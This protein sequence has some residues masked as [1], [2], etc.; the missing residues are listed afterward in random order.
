MHELVPDVALAGHPE[1]LLN[2]VRYF[3]AVMADVS[4]IL[5]EVVRFID[6]FFV[7]L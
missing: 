1:L 3:F 2:A 4:L 6:Q 5:A 7:D